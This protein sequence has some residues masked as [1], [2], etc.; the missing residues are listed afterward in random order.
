MSGV[1]EGARLIIMPFR[2]VN[3]AV[4]HLA[5]VV[6]SGGIKVKVILGNEDKEQTGELLSIDS[7]VLIFVKTLFSLLIGAFL[8]AGPQ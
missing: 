5:P 4:D 3:I 8:S 2:T 6:P 7:Q 1:G